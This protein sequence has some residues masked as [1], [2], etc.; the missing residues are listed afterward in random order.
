MGG[1]GGRAVPDDAGTGGGGEA[2]V[3]SFDGEGGG[4]EEVGSCA[5]FLGA[6][7]APPEKKD[8]I[9][10]CMWRRGGGLRRRKE[11]NVVERGGVTIVRDSGDVLAFKKARLSVVASSTNQSKQQAS[12]RAAAS[13]QRARIFIF[14]P[15]PSTAAIT[16]GY[17]FKIHQR[18][19]FKLLAHKNTRGAGVTC[20][21]DRCS[22]DAATRWINQ[23]TR[24]TLRGPAH[25]FDNCFTVTL[26]SH[27]L[28]H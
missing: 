8:A 20:A 19:L 24:L 7:A 4:R 27:L 17:R 6:A 12:H 10:L 15:T 25:C 26:C 28:G 23:L 13:K 18:M 5:D 22:H 9:D 21:T 11:R 16:T 14:K 1:R 3:T 2:S